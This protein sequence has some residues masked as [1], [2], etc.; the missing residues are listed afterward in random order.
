MT[1]IT[2]LDANTLAIQLTRELNVTEQPSSKS[3]WKDTLTDLKKLKD[4]LST[5]T[6]QMVIEIGFETDFISMDLSNQEFD[7]IF[8]NI[9][10]AG[11]ELGLG[12]SILSKKSIGKSNFYSG[13]VL[14]RRKAKCVEDVDELRVCCILA[15][16]IFNA[17]QYLH[18]LSIHLLF[19][20]WVVTNP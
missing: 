14:I 10:T 9:Q 5:V 7:E 20:T 18:W 4:Y 1:G 12:A 11:E 19:Y 3:T 6:T 17:L 2:A 8:Q 15:L 13:S 16:L